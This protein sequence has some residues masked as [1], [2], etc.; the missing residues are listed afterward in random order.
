[1]YDA[2]VSTPHEFLPDVRTFHS[3]WMVV[4]SITSY[5]NGMPRCYP[6]NETS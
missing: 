1:M 5:S 3:H 4:C 6:P 2:K